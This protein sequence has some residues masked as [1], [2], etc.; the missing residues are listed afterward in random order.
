MTA[1]SIAIGMLVAIFLLIYVL[2]RFFGSSHA[3]AMSTLAAIIFSPVVGTLM[4][5]L[6]IVTL[7][8]MLFFL[9]LMHVGKAILGRERINKLLVFRFMQRSIEIPACLILRDKV[10]IGRFGVVRVGASALAM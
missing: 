7:I 9:P 8:L 10:A 6:L 5:I 4:A 1:F 2:E 3:A